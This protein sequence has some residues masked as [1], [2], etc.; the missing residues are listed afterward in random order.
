MS[1]GDD[2][3]EEEDLPVLGGEGFTPEEL[4]QAEQQF[5]AQLVSP[6]CV[7]NA[8]FITHRGSMLG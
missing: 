1:E 6:S 3:S 7:R 2:D 8:R 5:S 4:A